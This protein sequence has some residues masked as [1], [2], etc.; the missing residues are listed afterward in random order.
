M[1]LQ[2]YER[3]L[4]RYGGPEA[5]AIW[6]MLSC[7]DSRAVR[8][9]LRSTGSAVRSEL[10]R[11]ELGVVS[12][13][14]LLASLTGH[15]PVERARWA[16]GLAGEA[17]AGGALFRER[18]LR[19]RALAQACDDGSWNELGGS[20]V[21]VGE[22]LAR[23]R[24]AIAPLVAQLQAYWADGTG[25]GLRKS[26]PGASCTCTRIGLGLDHH[27]EHLIL[28]VLDRTLR[29]LLAHQPRSHAERCLSTA[30]RGGFTMRDGCRSARVVPE[31][32]AHVASRV[33]ASTAP[34]PLDVVVAAQR[35]VGN[36]V[37][38]GLLTAGHLE[39]P[40]LG[41]PSFNVRRSSAAAPP[42]T[43]NRGR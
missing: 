39:P 8:G 3:E 26:C 1:V 41:L 27:T 18:K 9:L 40:L 4:E 13:A 10:D 19:L 15:D 43:L 16:Q 33:S 38:N 11:L 12:V 29:S 35:M 42:S 20:W 17:A 21:H 5:T 32:D 24:A 25:L 34:E 2:T 28:G 23:R 22:V 14:D 31:V 7:A 6:E 36:H 30:A 37:V